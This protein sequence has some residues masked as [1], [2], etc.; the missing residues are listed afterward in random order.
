MFFKNFLIKEI[1]FFY[2]NYLIILLLIMLII[3]RIKK[4]QRKSFIFKYLNYNYF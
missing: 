3:L 1:T 4:K 2:V